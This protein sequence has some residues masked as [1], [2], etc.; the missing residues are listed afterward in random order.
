MKHII[1]ARLGGVTVLQNAIAA[2]LA[3]R[4]CLMIDLGGRLRVL[5]KLG[6]QNDRVALDN[7]LGQELQ[8]A[9]EDYWT[10]EIWFDRERTHPMGKASPAEAA[11]FSKVW[12]EAKAEPAGQNHVLTLDRR[13]SKEAWFTTD[14]EAVWKAEGQ[15]PPIISFYSYKGGVGRTTALAALAIQCARAGKR[16]LVMDFDLEAPG[17]GSVFPAGTAVPEPGILDFLL[18]HPVVGNAFDPA[19]MVYS[20][21][22]Q[23]VIKDGEPIFVAAAGT[24]DEWY[25]EK[26]GR[27]NYH[28]LFESLAPSRAR[29]SAL[30]ILLHKLRAQAKPDLILIDSR[31][32]LHDLG[33]LT[34]SGLAHWHVLFGLDSEQSWLGL[35]VA[36]ARLGKEQ[37]LGGQT[38]RDC[39]VVQSMV[40]PQEGKEGSLERFRQQAFDVFRA[41]YYNDPNDPNAEWPLPDAKGTEEPHYSIPLVYDN[42]VMGYRSLEQVADYL[43]E[44]DFNAFGSAVVKK[45]GMKL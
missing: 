18:E 39:L 10:K 16:V 20:F 2:G 38:Q 7:R 15:M 31:A 34:L 41:E 27:L 11:L 8:T 40:P 32:G 22:N 28:G 4:L 36:V 29:N 24:V 33:G 9:C 35:R 5:A 30:R 12:Q 37:I 13:Y 23:A 3:E 42:R 1:E 44:G 26:L 14:V 43:G 45:V 25:L 6:D 17:I 19:E 21:D